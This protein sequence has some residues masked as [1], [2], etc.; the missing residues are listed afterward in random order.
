MKDLPVHSSWDAGECRAPSAGGSRERCR[1]RETVGQGEPWPLEN[2]HGHTCHRGSVDT[3]SLSQCG[4]RQRNQL[5]LQEFTG[6][7]LDCHCHFSLERRLEML[8]HREELFLYKP[9][10]QIHVLKVLGVAEVN[11][12][13]CYN[14]V[15]HL[16]SLILDL[17]N[18]TLSW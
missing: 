11:F 5:G 7:H 17:A 15:V 3:S 8:F 2:L 9:Y 1:G 6:R 4:D 18:L 13:T 16:P 12:T 10:Q 14:V